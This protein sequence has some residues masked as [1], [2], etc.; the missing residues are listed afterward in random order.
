MNSLGERF[1]DVI[2]RRPAGWLGR[3]AYGAPGGHEPSF[4][5]VMGWLGPIAGQECLEI[6]FGGGVLIERALAAG[7]T[8]VAGLDHSPDMMELARRRNEAAVTSNRTDLRVGDVGRLPWPEGSFDAAF[9]AN[10]F[11]FVE[12][13]GRA[14]GELFRV[15][16]PGGRL[17]IATM[18]APLPAPS[19]RLWWLYGP[20]G[21]ALR[22]YAD[23]EMEAMY[24]R[25]G[26]GDV[27]IESKGDGGSGLLD[28]M[29]RGFR[30]AS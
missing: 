27:T 24:G 22:V 19:L 3:Y 7:A 6:G 13:P 15:L 25:A 2:A 30:P 10:M 21:R 5:A 17:V 29:S 8:M 28:Q 23:A 26:F 9:C 14:L 20:M 1:V 18:G 12:D 4:R 11:F 16:R